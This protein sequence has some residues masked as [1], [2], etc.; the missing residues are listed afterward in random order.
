M[1]ETM[2]EKDFAK[3]YIDS[4]EYYRLQS[5]CS[6]VAKLIDQNFSSHTSIVI[7]PN[8]FVIKQDI[9]NGYFKIEV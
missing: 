1:C 8:D 6:E 3:S 2:S 5:L 7:T 9:L 4:V